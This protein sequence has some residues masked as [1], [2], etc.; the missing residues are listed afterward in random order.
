M[1]TTDETPSAGGVRRVTRRL[2]SSEIPSIDSSP[3]RD[4]VAALTADTE[5]QQLRRY[6]PRI[7]LK[8][9]VSISTI[10]PSMPRVGSPVQISADS[11]G[12]RLRDS[13][14]GFPVDRTIFPEILSPSTIRPD[15]SRPDLTERVQSL[16]GKNYLTVPSLPTRP[17]RPSVNRQF[18]TAAVRDRLATPTVEGVRP[19]LPTRDALLYGETDGVPDRDSPTTTPEYFVGVIPHSHSTVVSMLEESKFQRSYV[20]HPKVLSDD[21]FGIHQSAASIW[22]Y[23]PWS[24][25]HF[26]W[27]VPLFEMESEDA[28]YVFFHHEYNWLRHPAEHYDA[29]YLNPEWGRDRVMDLFDSA[30]ITL[31]PCCSVDSET[32]ELAA[33]YCTCGGAS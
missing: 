10:S 30:E 8:D 15:V 19:S 18:G 22:V 28:V 13:N 12:E 6:L 2:S 21:E 11:F 24:L 26:Q 27:H 17:S 5:S 25:S 1:G 4:R 7:D 20:T 33:A 14:P 29:E 16:G 23:R 32:H 3:L 9:H 31:E